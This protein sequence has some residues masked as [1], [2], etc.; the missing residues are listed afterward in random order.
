[1]HESIVETS[2]T[3]KHNQRLQVSDLLPLVDVENLWDVSY[4]IYQSL[5][6]TL[7]FMDKGF[8]GLLTGDMSP[9]LFIDIQKAIEQYQID[10]KKLEQAIIESQDKR[11][12]FDMFLD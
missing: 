6:V 8:K 2:E 3:D 12:I 10:Y 11:E 9:L 4:R 5:Q 1:M 7:E